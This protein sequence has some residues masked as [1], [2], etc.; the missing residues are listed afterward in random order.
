M[1][2]NGRPRKRR[3]LTPEELSEMSNNSSYLQS[4]VMPSGLNW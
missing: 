1:L 3:Q 4:A 2:E